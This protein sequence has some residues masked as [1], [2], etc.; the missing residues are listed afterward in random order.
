MTEQNDYKIQIEDI[1][2]WLD[3][4]LDI[5]N[6]QQNIK[7]FLFESIDWL[8]N[9]DNCLKFRSKEFPGSN[10]IMNSAPYQFI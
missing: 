8:E 6:A 7:K 2:V 5:I 1:T 9:C 3:Y 4:E 10:Q